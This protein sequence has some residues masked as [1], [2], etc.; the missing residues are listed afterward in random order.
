MLV[1]RRRSFA[2]YWKYFAARFNDV[3]AFGY[4]STG[5]ERIWMKFREL[6]SIL[7]GA[8]PDRFWARSAL[9]QERETLQKFFCQVNNARLCRFP[10]SQISRNLHTRHDSVTC[11]FRII[12]WKFALKGSFFP[13]K[14]WSSST[15][16]DFKLR[17]LGNDYK[18]WKI[19]TGWLAYGMLAFHPYR[20]NQLKVIP[21]DSRVHTQNEFH[22]YIVAEWPC[23]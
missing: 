5:S 2:E 3:H 7:F 21:L 1:T 4:N 20:W 23:S 6:L 19:M 18:S 8:G 11:F 14:P 17:F 9:K 13:K 16:S 12:F 22:R 10:V 15:I